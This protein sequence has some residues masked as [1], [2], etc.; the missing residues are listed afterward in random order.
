MEREE[1]IKIVLERS[2]LT[3]K[4]ISRFCA[5]NEDATIYENAKLTCTSVQCARMMSYKYNLKYKKKKG[6]RSSH[7]DFSDLVS[8]WNGELS[9]MENAK[10]LG[11]AREKAYLIKS[12]FNLPYCKTT[13]LGRYQIPA[14][15]NSISIKAMQALRQDGFT[16][17]KIGLLYGITRERVRQ[18]TTPVFIEKS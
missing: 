15:E 6:G 13:K 16:L 4:L 14:R 7:K 11:L 5:W 12:R 9:V 1:A 3:Q 17:E 8:G 18:L 10:I 2:T